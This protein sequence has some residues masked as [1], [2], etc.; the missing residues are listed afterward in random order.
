MLFSSS[1][2][3]T[4]YVPP[5]CGAAV[6][7][8][9]GVDGTGVTVGFGVAV[10]GT[11]VGGGAGFD[12]TGRWLEMLTVESDVPRLQ[13]EA[14][15]VDGSCM[16]TSKTTPSGTSS[17][18]PNSSRSGPPAECDRRSLFDVFTSL[19]Q[20]HYADGVPG[21]TFRS[22]LCYEGKVFQEA[23]RVQ[24]CNRTCTA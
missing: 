24:C 6:A 7:L 22:R 18:A 13:E 12:D 16:T 15:L 3:W 9:A 10:G 14:R 23:R 11:R 4:T 21:P 1:P 5:G 2:G 20:A 8:A 17:A 19:W